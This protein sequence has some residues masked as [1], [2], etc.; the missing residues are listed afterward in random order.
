MIVGSERPW[1]QSWPPHVGRSLQYPN[2]SA[3]WILT[4]NLDRHAQRVAIR[5]LDHET[6]EEITSLT[7]AELVRRAR[8]LAAG[9]RARGVAPGDRV[10][11]YLP[12]CP[13]VVVAYYGTWMAGA[14]V[15]PCNPMNKEAELE[16]QVTDSGARLLLGAAELYR[17]ARAV[18]GRAGIPLAVVPTN[19][20]SLA[21][22]PPDDL[23][24][25]DLLGAGELDPVPAANPADDLA[26]LLY[27]GGTT[28]LPKGAMLTHR[29]LV[30]NA[31][32]FSRWYNMEE[33]AEICIGVLPLAHS[34]GMAGA[35]NMPLVSGATILQF[36]RFN[37]LTVL[38]TIQKYRATRFFGVPTMYVAVLNTE[39]CREYD[40][41][42]LRHCRTSAAPLPAAV[43]AAFDELVGWGV[44]VEGYGLSETSPLIMA[45]PLDRPKAGSIG[46]PLPDSDAIIVDLETGEPLP[47][48]AEGELCLR[49]P[50]VMK[51][52]WNKPEATAAAMAGGWF[53]TGDIARMDEEGYFYIV[54]RKKDCIIS[55]GFKV[56]P[57]EVE[58][59]L[60]AHP[61]VRLAAVVGVPDDYRGEAVK[62]FVVLKDGAAGQVTAAELIAFCKE[63][64]AAY[65]VPRSI[66]FRNELPTSGAGKLLRRLL[67]NGG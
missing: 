52:Y 61:A 40:L 13:E 7:Y 3:W 20:E 16:H 33:G 63:R 31:I 25:A 67:R 29:N 58:E 9:L 48:G 26:L 54:D 6:G 4:R 22:L 45:N 38:K 21:E 47:P 18:A 27:T 35:M 51:G 49:G 19:G 59:A 43:K 60:Y 1:H 24:W 23:R 8:A 55:G 14:V 46:I 56:W 5:Y 17:T 2:E 50:Q 11:L 12:N 34:G 10:A 39:G 66:E 64:L 57:R 42:S 30:A 15:V 62:A 41:R 37:A 44:L 28:G 53:H 65:K 32:Q 36:K